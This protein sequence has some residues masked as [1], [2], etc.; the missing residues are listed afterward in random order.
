ML[1]AVQVEQARVDR[2]WPNARAMHAALLIGDCVNCQSHRAIYIA[3]TAGRYGIYC[4]GGAF[5]RPRKRATRV[6]ILSIE[7]LS[8]DIR[9]AVISI[10][11]VLTVC[12]GNEVSL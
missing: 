12:V 10:S 3:L 9:M 4:P 1:L 7:F 11:I 8:S 2:A 6:F 5:E